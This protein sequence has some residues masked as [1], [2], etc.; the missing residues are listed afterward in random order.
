M[1]KKSKQ[2]NV[3][4]LDIKKRRLKS[5]LKI[6]QREYPEPKC[7]LNYNNPYQLLI[8]CILSAQ[9]TDKRVNEITKELFVK[10]QSP[11]DFANAKQNTLEKDIHSAGFFR[12]K[13]R[14]I[15]FNYFTFNCE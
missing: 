5:I 13:A 2:I 15:I 9:C 11:R 10:Y 12:N 14:S 7:H 8:G 4:S 1:N 3:N 6:F